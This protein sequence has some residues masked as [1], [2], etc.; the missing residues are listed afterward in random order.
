M[1]SINEGSVKFPQRLFRQKIS[2]IE[3]LQKMRLMGEHLNEHYLSPDMDDIRKAA[4]IREIDEIDCHRKMSRHKR[5]VGSD[6]KKL[7]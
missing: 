1:G 6:N 2:E 4:R 3:D 7:D 5:I